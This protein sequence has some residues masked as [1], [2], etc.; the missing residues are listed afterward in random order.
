MR[1]ALPQGSPGWDQ[2]M[3]KPMWEMRQR[4][5]ANEI[6]YKEMFKILNR[7]KE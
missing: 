6:G 4:A 7:I 5:S 1:A 3:N 2:V